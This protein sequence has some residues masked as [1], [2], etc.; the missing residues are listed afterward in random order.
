MQHFNRYVIHGYR[1]NYNTNWLALRSLFQLHNE[2]GNVWTHLIGVLMFVWFT[3]Y[4]YLYL[5]QPAPTV[6]SGAQGCTLA[7][8]LAAPE[9]INTE[10][11]WFHSYYN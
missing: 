8:Q 2:T 7:D 9:Q 3:I 4:V 6:I 5:E 10:N 1:I 11:T